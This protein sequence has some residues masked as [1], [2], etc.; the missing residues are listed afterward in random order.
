MGAGT[1]RERGIG[2][3]GGPPSW[4]EIDEPGRDADDP[5]RVRDADE[6][7]RVDRLEVDSPVVVV[8]RAERPDIAEV[9]SEVVVTRDAEDTVRGRRPAG[10]AKPRGSPGVA[11]CA[12]AESVVAV[13]EDGLCVPAVGSV[14]ARRDEGTSSVG[15]KSLPVDVVARL[16]RALVAEMLVS[17]L[18]ALGDVEG[19]GRGAD[20]ESVGFLTAPRKAPRVSI[21]TM[22]AS[23]VKTGENPLITHLRYR[24]HSR[25]S[26]MDPERAKTLSSC[27]PL[28]M[29]TGQEQHPLSS[30]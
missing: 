29:E 25:Y 1:G 19:R 23:L 15:L 5:G 26:L 7:G 17:A 22:P 18:S 12:E 11:S 27:V 30:S 16:K 13:D 2:R 24:Q 9:D 6:V 8:V 21:S 28:S 20:I 3:T 4:Q 10:G 14:R